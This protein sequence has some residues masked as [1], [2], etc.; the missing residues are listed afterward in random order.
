MENYQEADGPIRIP[1]ALE[2]YM[3]GLTR[4]EATS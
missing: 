3:G 1:D 4:I 2:P